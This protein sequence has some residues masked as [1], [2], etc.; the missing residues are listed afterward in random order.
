ML[1]SMLLYVVS[2]QCTINSFHPLIVTFS[3]L[4]RKL[5]TDPSVVEMMLVCFYSA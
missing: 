1:L 2:V 3:A 5:F 4:N